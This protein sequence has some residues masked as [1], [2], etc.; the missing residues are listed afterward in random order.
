[1][2]LGRVYLSAMKHQALSLAVAALATSVQVAQADIYKFWCGRKY[3]AT[4][5]SFAGYNPGSPMAEYDQPHGDEYHSIKVVQGTMPYETGQSDVSLV[6]YVPQNVFDANGDLNLTISVPMLGANT[7]VTADQAVNGVSFSGRASGLVAG[8]NRMS[9]DASFTQYENGTAFSSWYDTIFFDFWTVEPPKEEGGKGLVAL[10]TLDQSVSVNGG[11]PFYPIGYYVSNSYMFSGDY[12]AAEAAVK[13][14]ASEGYNVLMHGGAIGSNA[15]QLKWTL[16]LCDK[17][18]LYYQCDVTDMTQNLTA[19]GLLVSDFAYK[20]KS[21]MSYYIGN[22]PDGNIGVGSLEPVQSQ[23]AYEFLKVA[24]P[25]HPVTLVTNC[26]HTMPIFGRNVDYAMTDVYAV[27]IPT[28]YNGLE[29][30]PFQGDC[31]CDLCDGSNPVKAVFDRWALV[32][33]DLGVQY[34]AMWLV[35]QTFYDNTSYW[36]RPPTYQEELA[37]AWASVVAG[38]SGVLGYTWPVTGVPTKYPQLGLALSDFA[39]QMSKYAADTAISGPRVAFNSIGSVYYASWASGT[40]VAMNIDY[41]QAAGFAAA[42]SELG[43]SKSSV[44]GQGL[45]RSS[46]SHAIDIS[47]HGGLL[48]D[49]LSPLEIKVYQ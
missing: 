3:N 24:D 45:G 19:L 37:M 49:Q 47:V 48:M 12:A 23:T 10:N 16:E 34:P 22:E 21:F 33:E 39:S 43:I 1:M 9:A 36:S 5:P 17:Y 44:K 8:K 13:K 46:S 32:Y 40:V 7:T 2:T 38:G 28:E 26:A 27:G 15:T 31:G 4:A 25:Y 30:T 41:K 20:Y 11:K 35:E 42:A 6:A 14:Y 29:C 18:D